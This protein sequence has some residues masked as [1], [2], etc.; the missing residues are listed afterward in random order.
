MI[1]LFLNI[2]MAATNP[3]IDFID[4]G[5]ERFIIVETTAKTCIFRIDKKT[6]NGGE[7]AIVEYVKDKVIRCV[8]DSNGKS[9][10]GN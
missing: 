10:D 1:G 5:N 8:K 9:N 3:H 7:D 2:A 4:R 6:F